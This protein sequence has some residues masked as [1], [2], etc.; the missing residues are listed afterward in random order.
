MH[1]TVTAS[2]LN[3]RTRPSVDASILGTLARGTRIDVVRRQGNWLQI[4]LDGTP[5]Y[6][7]A[8]YVSLPAPPAPD[9]QSAAADDDGTEPED[10]TAAREEPA[11]ERLEP[12]FRLPVS[13]TYQERKVAASWNR[14]GG[15]LTRLCEKK[16][17]EV[18]SAIAVLCVESS[19]KGFDRN[20]QNRMIIRFENHKFWK[21][22]GKTRPDLFQRHFQYNA[23]KTWTGHKWRADSDGE[24]SK[25]HGNQRMEWK[26]L[27]HARSLD[28]DAALL[29]ISMGAPQ[30]M[31]FH[32]QRIGYPSVQAMFDAFSTSMGAQITGLFDFL[33][34]AM[35]RRLQQQDFTG[36]AALYNGSGQKEKYGD[37][38]RNHFD[39]YRRISASTG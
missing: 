8:R 17:I 20:N 1:G 39:T 4:R 27:E 15:L 29:S 25:F 14:F 32:Y 38:I 3:V 33:D 36:F 28:N 6:V 5:A 26:V 19:G 11:D 35:V 7:S 22:W 9:A 30:I 31:G 2:R 21:Y 12:G 16:G 34:E 37:W 10:T 24:W 13:G 18:G 23:R